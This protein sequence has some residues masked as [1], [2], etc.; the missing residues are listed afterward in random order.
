MTKKQ[1][2]PTVNNLAVKYAASHPLPKINGEW[3]AA[4]CSIM[5]QLPDQIETGT[6]KTREVTEAKVIDGQDVMVTR[7]VSEPV[8][9]FFDTASEMMKEKILDMLQ[10]AYIEKPIPRLERCRRPD[11]A[12][13]LK[14]L[15]YLYPN[16]KDV[17]ET[18]MANYR[19]L[20][21]QENNYDQACLYLYSPKTGG[22]GKTFL[23]SHIKDYIHDLGGVA[24][25]VTTLK[26]DFLDPR[27]F[28]ANL[29]VL[30]DLN[31]NETPVETMNNLIDKNE[32][33]YNIKFGPKGTFVNEADLIVTS[34]YR[35]ANVNVR[36]WSVVEYLPMH[37]MNHPYNEKEYRQMVRDMM[38]CYPEALDTTPLGDGASQ[39]PKANQDMLNYLIDHRNV[40]RERPTAFFCGNEKMICQCENLVADLEAQGVLK[41]H[42]TPFRARNVNWNSLV[43]KLEKLG[44]YYFTEEDEEE[45]DSYDTPLD[46]C[47]AKWDE[48]IARLCGEGPAPEPPRGDGGDSF[49]EFVQERLTHFSDAKTVSEAIDAQ[50]SANCV[51]NDGSR[52]GLHTK[53][54]ECRPV[55]MAFESDTL[56]L[57]EQKANIK[58]SCWDAQVFSGN[59]S[60]HV[61]VRI[62]EEISVELSKLD[63]LVRYPVYHRLYREVAERLFKD[64]SHL[65]FN[66]KSWLRKFRTPFGFRDNGVRQDAEFNETPSRLPWREMLEYCEICQR[67]MEEDAK[68]RNL[69]LNADRKTD[70]SLK[71]GVVH[72]LETPYRKLTGNGDSD[73]SLYRA[74]VICLAC[75]DEGTL[76]EVLNKARM[77]H[78][79]E[80][81]LQAKLRSA[82]EFT[83]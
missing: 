20:K 17:R 7:T 14:A 67:R 63:E 4:V 52:I 65:D 31:M 39:A 30:E 21:S 54:G 83:R 35:P 5:D 22:T 45:Y 51:M 47:A 77:E 48:A 66:C 79:T 36:R 53:K 58:S 8:M 12:K 82:R 44:G 41:T 55:V 43:T 34:N 27:Q 23:A 33:S 46:Y 56:S 26:G 81:E 29:V 24:K 76:E 80:N 32:M 62:P 70:A 42:V 64:V 38:E 69:N 40:Q 19:F 1:I 15:K 18:I 6:T 73:S 10:K 2:D 68:S 71:E 50:Y 16:V 59:K 28:R 61:L 78:W 37:M 11:L 60:L 9:R 49:D 3:I 25:S 57:E 72:Y 74:I 13:W 75:H